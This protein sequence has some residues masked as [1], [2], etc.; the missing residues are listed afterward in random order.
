MIS[1][2]TSTEQS[3]PSHSQGYFELSGPQVLEES[4]EKS[5]H[6]TY[7]SSQAV[8]SF[9]N[10]VPLDQ[11][12]RVFRTSLWWLLQAHLLVGP[13]HSFSSHQSGWL[14][15]SWI[16]CSPSLGSDLC[17]EFASFECLFPL[18]QVNSDLSLKGPLKH[19]YQ[20]L[21]WPLPAPCC[22]CPAL[23]S[24]ML[25]QHFVLCI[26]KALFPIDWTLLGDTHHVLLDI[27]F[28]VS[29]K[30][31]STDRESSNDLYKLLLD[32]CSPQTTCVY[33]HPLHSE[34]Q[35]W[36]TLTVPSSSQWPLC[37]PFLQRLQ[38]ENKGPSEE[39]AGHWFVSRKTVNKLGEQHSYFYQLDTFQAS[40]LAYQ[41]S[42]LKRSQTLSSH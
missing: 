7:E 1:F 8:Q 18:H 27:M 22:P 40:I 26:Y 19:L 38:C 12:T 17:I 11:L 14:A 9:Q 31:L 28:P 16:Y 2:V 33:K 37:L 6:I 25:P 39:A 35:P 41:V 5:I 30:K 36:Q 34:T 32:D 29:S 21:P 23:C 20:S 4:Q 42:A 10:K 13:T 15:V 3:H 24:F